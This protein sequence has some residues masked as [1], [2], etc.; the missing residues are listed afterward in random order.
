M[1]A[2]IYNDGVMELTP[3]NGWIFIFWITN[4]RGRLSKTLIRGVRWIEQMITRSTIWKG[5]VCN[6]ERDH[7]EM[8]KVIERMGGRKCDEDPDLIFF[9]KEISHV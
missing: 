6:S 2:A 7:T 4:D 9:K 5:W 8:H 1:S 3:V